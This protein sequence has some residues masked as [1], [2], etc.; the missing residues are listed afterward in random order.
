M[1]SE[2]KTASQVLTTDELSA[3]REAA[4]IALCSPDRILA[5]LGMLE[6]ARRKNKEILTEIKPEAERVVFGYE[7]LKDLTGNVMRMLNAKLSA[8]IREGAEAHE[9]L[10]PFA[11]AFDND[12]RVDLAQVDFDHFHRARA[13]LAASGK[14]DSADV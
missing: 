4:E 12:G 9:A 2:K 8:A 14:K 3:L 10:K 5:L 11:A 7:N 6:E 1:M 13:I